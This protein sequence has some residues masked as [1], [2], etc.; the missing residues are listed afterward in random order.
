MA[1]SITLGTKTITIPFDGNLKSGLMIIL[2]GHQENS[3]IYYF[4]L[5]DGTQWRFGMEN[6]THCIS[7]ITFASGQLQIVVPSDFFGDAGEFACIIQTDD[8]PT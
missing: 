3:Y 8:F 5:Y 4:A 6:T 1:G 7:S 2:C